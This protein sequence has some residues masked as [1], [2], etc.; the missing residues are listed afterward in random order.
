M[1]ILYSDY[2]RRQKS[3][4]SDVFWIAFDRNKLETCGFQRLIAKTQEHIFISKIFSEKNSENRFFE[5]SLENH[6]EF[7][8]NA[9]EIYWF[10]YIFGISIENWVGSCMFRIS[11]RTF[12]FVEK[13]TPSSSQR[14]IKKWIQ[15]KRHFYCLVIYHFVFY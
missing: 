14:Q 9:I 11:S 8:K 13:L 7:L 3:M 6:A 10:L 15:S 5:G 4:D 1:I 12:F 2:Y